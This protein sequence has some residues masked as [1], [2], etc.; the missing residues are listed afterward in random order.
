MRAQAFDFS[1]NRGWMKVKVIQT[2][3]IRYCYVLSII[4]F[5]RNWSI[6]VQMQANADLG[7]GE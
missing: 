4:K 5:K 1:S 7:G 3:I 2:G 6:Y